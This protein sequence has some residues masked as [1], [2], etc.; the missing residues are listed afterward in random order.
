M[1]FRLEQEGGSLISAI[2]MAHPL[3]PINSRSRNKRWKLSVGRC[4]MCF[5]LMTS[6]PVQKLCVN[7]CLYIYI[8]IYIYI[9]VYMYIN[10]CV[11]ILYTSP[12][13]RTY[14]YM[15]REC[16]SVL[17]KLH[18]CTPSQSIGLFL[19]SACFLC[20]MSVVVF[21]G[22]TLRVLLCDIKTLY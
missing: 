1:R 5:L 16:R 18:R 9:Y 17:M 20:W 15:H 6:V 2:A 11:C 8:Y 22:F 7:I 3:H 19:G 4:V 21:F 13:Y 12:G 10:I 14:K